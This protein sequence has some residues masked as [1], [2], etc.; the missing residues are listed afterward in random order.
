MSRLRAQ[1][2]RAYAALAFGRAAAIYELLTDQEAWRR[3]CR[4]MAELVGGPRVLDLG[5]GPGTSALEMARADPS[6]RHVGLDLSAAMLRRAAGRA[7]AERVALPL[8][9][10]DVLALPVR[11]GAFDA[12]TGHSFLYLLDDAA[13]SLREVRRA[14]RPGGRV[15]FLEPRAG[16]ARLRDAL[17]AGPRN[18]VAMALW[19]SMSRLH[20][21]Y[22]EAS[23]PALLAHAGFVEARAWPVLSGY[24][25]MAI[26]VRPE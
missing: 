16:R 21:R 2:G 13:A 3:D 9:R 24:G 18:G 12:A 10:A 14:V 8:L 7:R 25:V 5:V 17:R 19:R 15:A 6:R 11:E 26:A 22:D 1:A 20:R 23:L 4:D